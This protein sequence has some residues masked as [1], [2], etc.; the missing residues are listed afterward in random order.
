M[1]ETKRVREKQFFYNFENETA[2]KNFLVII[3]REQ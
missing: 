3:A 2:E 1:F